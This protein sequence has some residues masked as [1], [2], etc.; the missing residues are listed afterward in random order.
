MLSVSTLTALSDSHNA[1]D[2]CDSLYVPFPGR[3]LIEAPPSRTNPVR[4]ARARGGERASGRK[5]IMTGMPVTVRRTAEI[6]VGL[7]CEQAMALFTAEGERQWAEGWDPCYPEPDRREGPGAVFTT[8]HGGHKTTWIMVDHEPERIRYARVTSGMTAG[9][10]A[11]RCARLRRGL[12]AA[13]CYLRPGRAQ[14]CGREVARC[15]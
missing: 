7:P 12:H 2:D 11:V 9:T 1:V 5:G 6:M 4:L 3:D 10:V 14:P 8:A 15:V 13:P